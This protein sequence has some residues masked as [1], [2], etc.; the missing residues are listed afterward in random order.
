[1]RAALDGPASIVSQEFK[2]AAI[3]LRPCVKTVADQRLVHLGRNSTFYGRNGTIEN[4]LGD[5]HDRKI[6]Q[7]RADQE[8]EEWWRRRDEPKPTTE[9]KQR[10]SDCDSDDSK[11]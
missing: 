6:R 10:E 1:H 8:D 9:G 11:R 7:C 5:F 3:A 4:A 2:G